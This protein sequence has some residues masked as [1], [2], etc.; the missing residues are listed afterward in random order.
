MSANHGKLLLLALPRLMGTVGPSQ[1]SPICFLCQDT[2]EF[3]VTSIDPPDGSAVSGESLQLTITG[4]WEY[5]VNV[6]G[7]EMHSIYLRK[8]DPNG[9]WQVVFSPY[10]GGF[11]R[12]DGE[13]Y[14][15]D[16]CHR[17]REVTLIWP[18]V[19]L[20]LDEDTFTFKIDWWMDG[21]D[22]FIDYHDE[23]EP[24]TYHRE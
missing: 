9:Q 21:S 13:A 5:A 1:I 22:S 6:S 23:G 18:N 8:L 17:G 15:I 10:Q 20:P 24:F 11:I 16:N 7:P 2:N 3:Y 19:P 12:I 14:A 4:N